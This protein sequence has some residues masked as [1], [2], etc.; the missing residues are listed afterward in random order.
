MHKPLGPFGGLGRPGSATAGPARWTTQVPAAG[1][2]VCPV[3]EPRQLAQSLPPTGHSPG[4]KGQGRRRRGLP[5][6]VPNRGR[7]GPRCASDRGREPTR[8]SFLRAFP[9]SAPAAP[10]APGSGYP[11]RPHPGP[12]LWAGQLGRRGAGRGL[13]GGAECALAGTPRSWRRGAGPAARGEGAAEAMARRAEGA[14]LLLLVSA[15][16]GT[17]SPG[18]QG[19]GRAPGPARSRPIRLRPPGAPSLC[20]EVGKGW[21][22]CGELQPW[23]FGKT[24]EAEPGGLEPVHSSVLATVPTPFFYPWSVGVESPGTGDTFPGDLGLCL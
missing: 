6:R 20:P 13:R 15:A 7:H 14:L 24:A 10:T 1:S 22:G 21:A 18:R 12:R 3:A 4:R 23:G 16:A 17:R 2:E 5:L 8:A 9:T 19:H 11:R